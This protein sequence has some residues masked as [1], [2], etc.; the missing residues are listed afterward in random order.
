MSMTKFPTFEKLKKRGYFYCPLEDIELG[1][2]DFVSKLNALPYAA[3][4]GSCEGHAREEL[5]RRGWRPEEIDLEYPQ[6]YSPAY[7]DVY[8]TKARRLA[9]WP[10]LE[11]MIDMDEVTIHM[12]PV[13]ES[14]FDY[15]W[16]DIQHTE[17]DV[18]DVSIVSKK[19]FMPLRDV[20]VDVHWL[21]RDLPRKEE[22]F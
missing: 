17:D 3:T 11:N 21:F 16:P 7:V 12:S 13:K 2:R 14:R 6:G 20:I 19:I 8:V 9:F 5:L 22:I 10:W 1:I 15:G 4:H 18:F